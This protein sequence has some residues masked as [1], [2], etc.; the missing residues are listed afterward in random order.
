[1]RVLRKRKRLNKVAQYKTACTWSFLH[2]HNYE[3][4]RPT[5]Y[6][7]RAKRE[8]DTLHRSSILQNA[9]ALGEKRRVLHRR[10]CNFFEPVTFN[11]GRFTIIMTQEPASRRVVLH[12]TSY[13]E[14]VSQ[15]IWHPAEF[16]TPE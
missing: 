8:R 16:G 15:R 4:R 13:C 2:L 3:C 10:F 1:M 7:V 12:R 5:A 14:P 6:C 11:T 9:I